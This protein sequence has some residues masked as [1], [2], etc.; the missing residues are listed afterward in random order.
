MAD[1]PREVVFYGRVSGH[2]QTEAGK[3]GFRRQKETVFHFARKNSISIVG[4]F[5]E[6]AVSGTKEID[7]RPAFQDM[8]SYLLGNGCRAIAVESLDRLAREFRIQEQI[9]IYLL[10]KGIDIIAA[11]TGENVTQAIAD[12]P[13]K[14]ALV[15]IQG[16]FAELDK[17][18]IVRKLRKA[19]EAK[20][21]KGQRC[22][23]AKPYG[24]LPNEE[25]C[26]KR[27]K[28][29]YRKPKG[30]ARLGYSKIAQILNQEG[31]RNRSG[32][33]WTRNSVYAL[34]KK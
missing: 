9:L 30:K 23:G 29:L 6:K 12:D 25:Q 17:S 5:L 11:N 7:Q 10:S 18:Q 31:Y 24:E 22:E 15:Q 28:T 13:M 8:L 16:V 27:M 3:D 19:R 34:L 33:L 21:K 20:R 4:E 32:G 14:K 2:S 1:Y 26:L